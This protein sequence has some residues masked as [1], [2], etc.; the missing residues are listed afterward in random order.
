[1]EKFHKKF[2][3]KKDFVQNVFKIDYIFF[4]NFNVLITNFTSDLSWLNKISMK[5][6]SH[7]TQNEEELILKLK[8]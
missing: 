2:T 3:T 5:K 8:A 4:E 1:M 6:S 7:Q